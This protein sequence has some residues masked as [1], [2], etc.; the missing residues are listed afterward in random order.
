MLTV[1]LMLL[2]TNLA[3]SFWK[4]GARKL[5]M[6]RCIYAHFAILPV[7]FLSILK[8]QRS[9][10][11]EEISTPSSG[12][13]FLVLSSVLILADLLIAFSSPAIKQTTFLANMFPIEVCSFHTYSPKS[14]RNL[15]E[16]K[17]QF[18]NIQFLAFADMIKYPIFLT[19]L[20]FLKGIPFAI[21]FF[22]WALV[23]VCINI[24]FNKYDQFKDNLKKYDIF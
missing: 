11:I 8:L 4:K 6:I 24:R 19:I 3:I 21:G 14:F 16:L 9:V 20:G 18:R 1:Y 7:S 15:H 13:T 22:L 5:G 10:R 2:A 17:S 23:Y 12:V